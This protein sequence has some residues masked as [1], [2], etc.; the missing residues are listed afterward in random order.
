MFETR[1]LRSIFCAKNKKS[2]KKVPKILNYAK[3]IKQ[4][5]SCMKHVLDELKSIDLREV[6]K[7]EA[8]DFTDWLAKEEHLSKLGEVIGVDI[9]LIQKEPK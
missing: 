1:Q 8:L 9:E 7:H 5:D 4:E 6:W 2:C 3:I